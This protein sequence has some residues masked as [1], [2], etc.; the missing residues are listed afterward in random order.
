MARAKTGCSQPCLKADVLVSFGELQTAV[1]RATCGCG[2]ALGLA[3]RTGLIARHMAWQNVNPLGLVLSA[4]TNS[5]EL[6]E[7]PRWITRE[8]MLRA[9]LPQHRTGS[10][11]V[12]APLAC[13]WLLS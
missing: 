4:L 7:A 13:D 3:R 11:I 12:R 5:E 8:G 9:D 6:A 10:A 1:E 2:V